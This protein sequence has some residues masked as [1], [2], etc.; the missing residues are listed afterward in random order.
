MKT[1]KEFLEALVAI[2]RVDNGDLDEISSLI[3]ER[4]EQLE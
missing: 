1:E 4:I 3:T 2:F